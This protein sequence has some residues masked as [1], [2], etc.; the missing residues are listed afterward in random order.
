MSIFAGVFALVPC[1]GCRESGS[2]RTALF[3]N[4][5]GSKKSYG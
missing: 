5:G 3:E 1:L 4:G 2:V